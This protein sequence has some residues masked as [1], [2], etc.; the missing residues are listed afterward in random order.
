KALSDRTPYEAFNN[1]KPSVSH[2]QPFGRECYV[3][4]P[5][6]K[7]PAGMKLTSRA[8]KGLFVGYTNIEQHYRVFIPEQ[9]RTF[10]S[11]DVFFPPY[12]SEGAIATSAPTKCRS[13][14]LLRPPTASA[15]T[16]ATSNIY[17]QPDPKGFPNDD[18][19]LAWMERNPDIANQWFDQG[20]PKVTQLFESE[21]QQ[22]RRDA[23]LG[24]QYWDFN[25]SQSPPQNTAPDRMS[26][27]PS[28]PPSTP[29][30]D[31]PPAQQQPV[32][33]QQGTTTRSGRTIRPPGEW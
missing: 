25:E 18:I 33:Q 29:T 19:W 31:H 13:P 7:R 14:S 1:K 10:I 27:D 11:R 2:L 20:H 32:P 16:P 26:I 22:G 28:H 23:F 4:I 6:A 24:P 3:H 8:E 17:V 12:K 30:N 9:K 21:F 15:D 5:L